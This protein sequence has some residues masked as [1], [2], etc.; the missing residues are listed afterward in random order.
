MSTAKARP[1]PLVF[2]KVKPIL[3]KI[4]DTARSKELRI[5]AKVVLALWL[6]ET[7]D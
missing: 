7:T 1:K 3:R 2:E 4:A 5:I 6:N